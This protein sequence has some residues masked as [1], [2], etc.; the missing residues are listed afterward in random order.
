LTQAGTDGSVLVFSIDWDGA[1]AGIEG[2]QLGACIDRHLNNGNRNAEFDLAASY[3]WSDRSE[4]SLVYSDVK[5]PDS[6]KNL[7][8]FYNYTF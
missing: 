3:A 1:A 6:F 2:L 5:T 4:L 7:R 8:I